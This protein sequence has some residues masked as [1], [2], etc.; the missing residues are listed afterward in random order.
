M[1]NKVLNY[2]GVKFLFIIISLVCAVFRTI[3]TAV[4]TTINI[5]ITTKIKVSHIG[6]QCEHS[7][8]SYPKKQRCHQMGYFFPTLNCPCTPS[9]FS[10]CPTSSWNYS[11]RKQLR[12]SQRRPRPHDNLISCSSIPPPPSEH[13][14]GWRSDPTQTVDRRRHWRCDT[15]LRRRH[16]PPIRWGNTPTA[17]LREGVREQ[18]LRRRMEGGIGCPR[19]LWRSMEGWWLFLDC[20]LWHVTSKHHMESECRESVSIHSVLGCTGNCGNTSW[21]QLKKINIGTMTS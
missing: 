14:F 17:S 6:C 2:I 11:Q 18:V 1:Q 21:K 16:N 13:Q 9:Y 15:D 7:W 10:S 12:N 20:V 8:S 4:T 5:F 3:I 19:R